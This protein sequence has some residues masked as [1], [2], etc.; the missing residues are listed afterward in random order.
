MSP[1]FERRMGRRHAVEPY[2]VAWR[3]ERASSG[4]LGRLGRKAQVG[5]LLDVSVSGA[6]IRAPEAKD[7]QVGA[8]TT[9][10]IRGI[11]GPVAIRRI[12]PS[13][14][15]GLCVYGVELPPATSELTQLVHRELLADFS[16]ARE[17]DWHHLRDPS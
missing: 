2:D 17:L 13:D 16:S 10:A 14:Q 6:R 3:V 11:R 12:T 9:I 5:T 8:R 7:L 4:L 1:S 15:P